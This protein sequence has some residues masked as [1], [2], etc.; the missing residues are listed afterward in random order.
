M[1]QSFHLCVGVS[2]NRE[3]EEKK[4]YVL[5]PTPELPMSPEDVRSVVVCRE[6]KKDEGV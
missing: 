4:G 1:F 3:E 2:S 6:G 5:L